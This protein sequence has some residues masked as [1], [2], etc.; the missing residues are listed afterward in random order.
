MFAV[1]GVDYRDYMRAKLSS[2]DVLASTGLDFACKKVEYVNIRGV[3]G[4]DV[5]IIVYSAP[6]IFFHVESI[7]A[8]SKFC[9]FD[10]STWAVLSEN[11][12]G[13]YCYN[14]NKDFRGCATD[15]S[16]TEYWFG[17]YL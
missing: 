5:T 4:R 6:S 13:H 9:Q 14:T 17:G 8:S 2:V 15:E 3:I 10:G 16:T 11:N 7:I 1:H 12:F